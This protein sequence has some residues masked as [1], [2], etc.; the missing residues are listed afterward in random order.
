MNAGFLP[1]VSRVLNPKHKRSLM[2]HRVRTVCDDLIRGVMCGVDDDDFNVPD[3]NRL[4]TDAEF[5]KEVY[6]LKS[7]LGGESEYACS[8]CGDMS[9][10]GI[11]FVPATMMW[12]PIGIKGFGSVMAFDC[13]QL[14]KSQFIVCGSTCD[15]LL[16]QKP[17][18]PSCG[19]VEEIKWSD[20]TYVD[21]AYL[22]NIPSMHKLLAAFTKFD[23]VSA[24]IRERRGRMGLTLEE[25]KELQATQENHGVKEIS[26]TWR[27]PRRGSAVRFASNVGNTFSL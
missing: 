24:E 12:H 5:E 4:M 26:R 15:D 18:C 1:D 2:I 7:V 21:P 8:V 19:I 6:G 9:H 10:S 17:M 23:N 22:R 14:G 3:P 11:F 20:E 13:K 16:K 27:S 25:T